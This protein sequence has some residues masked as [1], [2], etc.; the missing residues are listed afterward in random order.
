MASLVLLSVFS[1]GF[2]L[3]LTGCGGGGTGESLTDSSAAQFVQQNM[4]NPP[5]SFSTVDQEVWSVYKSASPQQ[6]KV[7]GN[8][9]A[10]LF[11]DGTG[12][13]AT[14]FIRFVSGSWQPED[15]VT[16]SETNEIEPTRSHC[17]SVYGDE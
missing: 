14:A 15:V 2:A 4:G 1:I 11:R 9:A 16:G 8:C 12:S 5:S 3:A 17:D 13:T 6:E 10:V 7:A